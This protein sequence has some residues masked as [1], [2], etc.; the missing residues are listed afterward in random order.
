MTLE[1]YLRGEKRCAQTVPREGIIG[2]GAKHPVWK[3]QCWLSG[4]RQA[5]R[6]P[7]SGPSA[8]RRSSPLWTAIRRRTLAPRKHGLAWVP[9]TVQEKDQALSLGAVHT[10]ICSWEKDKLIWDVTGPLNSLHHLNSTTQKA[11]HCNPSGRQWSQTASGNTGGS[12]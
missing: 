10:A 2:T 5:T 6:L 7:R 1:L 9:L 11:A 8:V 12:P 3:R 4:L